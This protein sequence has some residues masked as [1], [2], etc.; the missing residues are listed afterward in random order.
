[1]AFWTG[2]LLA[3]PIVR[4]SSGDTYGTHHSILGVGGYMEV[5]SIAERNALPVDTVNG[6]GYDGISSGQRRIGMLVYVHEDDTIYQLKIS[7]STWNGLI[8]ASKIT[9]LANNSNWE[10]FVT[11]EDQIQSG[12]KIQKEFTQTTHGFIKGDVIGYDGT[13]FVKVNSVSAGNI[14]PLGIVSKVVDLNNFKLTFAGYISTSGITDVNSSGLTGGSVY[15]LSNTNGKITLDKPTGSTEIS[16]PMLV[17]ITDSTGIVLQYRGIY[18]P[19]TSGGTV[20]YSEFTGYTASTQAFLN[21]TVTGATNIGYFTGRTGIQILPINNLNDNDYDG[22]YASVYNNYYRDKNG[23]INIG[24]PSDNIPR[25]G[26]VKATTPAKSWIWNEYT[27]DSAPNGWIFIDGDVTSDNIYGTSI[28]G[29]SVNYS[30]PAYT[31]AT[32]NNGVSYNNG[33]QIVINTVQGSI[34]TGSTYINGGPVYNDK[35]NKE[36]RLR[37]IISDTPDIIDVSHDNYYI[38]ISG[39]SHVPN[40]QNIGTGV[41]VYSGATGNTQLFKKLAGGGNTTITDAGDSVV[42]SSTASVSSISSE[43]VTKSITQFGHGFSVGDVVGWSGSTYNK[44]IA[45][46]TYGGEI[47][48][49]VSEVTDVNNFNLTQSGYITGLTGFIENTTYFVS[50]TISGNLTNIEPTTYGYLY[51]PIFVANSATSGWVFPDRGYIITPIGSGTTGGTIY[52]TG[53][54]PSV[55]SVGGLPASTDLTG[56]TVS[57]ILEQIL[58]PEQCGT[59]TSPSTSILLSETGLYEV[60]CSITQTVTSNF[61]RGSINPQYCSVSPYRSGPANAYCFDGP[62]MPSGFQLCTNTSASQSTGHTI[63]EGTQLWSTFTRYDCGEPALSSFGNQYCAALPS[64]CTTS[65]SNSIIGV[66][67]LWAT[68]STISS[69]DKISPLYN[70]ST[71]NNIEINLAAESGGNKQ[72]FEIPCAW[73]S[74]RSLTGVQQYNTVSAQWEY[75]G[76]NASQSLTLWNGSSVTET[77]QGNSVGYCQYTH[78]CA[79]RSSVCIRLVF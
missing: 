15:Y 62:G 66:Y 19:I 65:T 40:A 53:K 11:G 79:D 55:C 48:G 54:T 26:Y 5:N 61:N 4:G 7:Q 1:M 25:R 59:I 21:K 43:N 9:A 30:V 18:D 45:D 57:E 78:A 39:S 58:V 73:L 31:A 32:W 23:V 36:L 10:V 17:T 38:K 72:K 22:D 27:G 42:I 64:G 76:G 12:E 6:I 67:P 47:I 44:A 63:I 49:I 35:Q 16:K 3:S 13:E 2:T 77:V 20:S 74:S 71:A 29:G 8:N 37:S 75:P 24:I 41:S 60:G 14:E 46:G 69:I 50:S 68:C 52:Y 34:S 51:R 33:S 56:K 70:M 28:T